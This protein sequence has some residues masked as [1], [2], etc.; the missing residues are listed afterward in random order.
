MR[1]YG[2]LAHMHKGERIYRKT[3]SRSCAFDAH[4]R[5]A[6]DLLFFLFD[7]KYRVYENPLDTMSCYSMGNA[8]F[9]TI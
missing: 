1:I 7:Q 5:E 9:V 8:R 2:P 3:L 4:I 6:H